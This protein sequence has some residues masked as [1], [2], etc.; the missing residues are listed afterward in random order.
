MSSYL[1]V[2][3]HDNWNF[4]ICITICLHFRLRK[5]FSP[6]IQRPLMFF[7]EAGAHLIKNAHGACS[8]LSGTL[9]F[10]MIPHA[11]VIWQAGHFKKNWLLDGVQLP[12]ACSEI[13]CGSTLFAPLE[14]KRPRE[15]RK[16]LPLYC[17]LL[18]RMVQRGFKLVTSILGTPSIL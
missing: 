14:V 8:F 9:I 12:P 5:G 15:F 11:V 2:V 3:K 4:P 18:F 10:R 7:T 13:G 17:L 6:A 1:V 16:H